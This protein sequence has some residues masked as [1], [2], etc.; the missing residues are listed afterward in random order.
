MTSPF[1]W[2]MRYRSARHCE[3]KGSGDEKKVQLFLSALTIGCVLLALE[4]L[5][6][7]VAIVR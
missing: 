1:E 4:V 6:F 5:T 7:F 3:R 2:M